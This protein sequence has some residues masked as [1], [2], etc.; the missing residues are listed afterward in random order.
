MTSIELKQSQVMC[1][2]ILVSVVRFAALPKW[3]VDV[4]SFRLDC[5]H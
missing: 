2:D 1:I 5:E 4:L 3:Y